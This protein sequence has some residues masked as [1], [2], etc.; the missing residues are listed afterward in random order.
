ME[1]AKCRGGVL[2]SPLDPSRFPS[3][4]PP[5]NEM[6]YQFSFLRLSK[7]KDNG[8]VIQLNIDERERENKRDILKILSIIY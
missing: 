6:Q 4:D 2:T 1:E 5:E 8:Y 7:E 3:M